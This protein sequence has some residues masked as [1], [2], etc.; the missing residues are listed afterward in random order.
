MPNVLRQ[1]LG[2]MSSKRNHAKWDNW[3]IG[4]MLVVTFTVSVVGDWFFGSQWS[5]PYW[6][7]FE[8]VTWATGLTVMIA[9]LFWKDR[10][11]E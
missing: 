6:Y 5:N 4:G 3:I 11:P 8:A 2:N 10:R 7:L 9:L 1:P